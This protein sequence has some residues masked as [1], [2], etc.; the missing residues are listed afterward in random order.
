MSEEQRDAGVESGQP[1]THRRDFLRQMALS[2][3][4][5]MVAGTLG[6]GAE[7]GAVPQ[8]PAPKPPLLAKP[9]DKVP[10]RPLGKTGV[11]VPCLAFGI[12]TPA[13]PELFD[14]ALSWGIDH[15]DTAASYAGAEGA[16]GAYLAAHKGLRDK[17]FIS[18]KPPD[19][20]TPEPEYATMEASLDKS[21]KLIGTDRIDLFLGIHA[22]PRPT[23]LTDEFLR[24]G[25]DMKKKGKIR[26]FGFSNHANLSDNLAK[27]ATMKGIDAILVQYNF[28]YVNNAKLRTSLEA[29]TKAGIGLVAIKGQGFTPKVNDKE[30]AVID[31]FANRGFNQAQAKIKV[32]MEEPLIASLS[33]GMK[34]L[35]II[36]SSAGAAL[37]KEK[38]SALDRQVLQAYA[39]NTHCTSCAGC[40]QHCGGPGL[41]HTAVADV[42]RCLMYDRAYQ[43]PAFAEQAFAQ[44]T[45]E[46]RAYLQHGDLLAA[47]GRCPHDLP[48]VSMVDEALRRFATPNAPA[49]T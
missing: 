35:E 33:V 37:I 11:D 8:P 44:I 42:M 6:A 16:I 1:L 39:F 41:A 23:C 27:A 10:R 24:F 43:E 47:E 12:T 5:P 38:L 32:V 20:N 13:K 7:A 45:P 18:T 17:V 14:R 21:L 22:C 4:L 28:R 40:V 25:E 9:G 49:L 30:Q 15:W 26:F 3:L 34:S 46:G 29:C 2:S 36:D 48:I 19:I 31:A